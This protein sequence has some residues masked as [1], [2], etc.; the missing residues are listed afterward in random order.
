MTKVLSSLVIAAV[1]GLGAS[2]TAFATEPAKTVQDP[3]QKI[4]K[5]EM[6]ANSTSQLQREMVGKHIDTLPEAE[7]STKAVDNP[8]RIVCKKIARMG[9]RLR[10][11][12]VCAT[13]KEWDQMK[14][15]TVRG[16]RGMQLTRGRS[17]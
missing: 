12:K 3:A 14:S 8:D 6:T 2:T 5:Q 17:D 10:K 4:V 9:T 11:R 1:L 13:K 15:D 7:E 16:V